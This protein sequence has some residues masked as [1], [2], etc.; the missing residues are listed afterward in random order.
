MAHH[1]GDFPPPASEGGERMRENVTKVSVEVAD[2]EA[3]EAAEA[4]LGG[5][6]QGERE[7]IG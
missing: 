4:G 5:R 3:A 7:G 2:E 6:Q 1:R